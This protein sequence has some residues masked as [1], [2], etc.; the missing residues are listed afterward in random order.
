MVS[1]LPD[2][3]DVLEFWAWFASIADDLADDFMNE[4]LQDALD[5]RLGRLGEV[6]WELGPGATA[7]NAL[8]IS[9]DG[10]PD[11]LPL[12]Q[13]IV[14]MAP[15]LRRWEFHPARPARS[16]SMEFLIGTS[17]DDEIAIDARS[18][19]YV[20]FEYPDLT[21]DVVLEQANLADVSDDER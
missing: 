17:G 16:E 7:E 18:W 6:A 13:R 3:S 10:D 4:A 8:A 2:D 9:P 19:R 5:A 20:L 14:A 15:E 1:T 21:F 11:L 12:T